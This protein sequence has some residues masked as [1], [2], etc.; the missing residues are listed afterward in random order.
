MIVFAPSLCG[1]RSSSIPVSSATQARI[2]ISPIASMP[3]CGAS[4]LCW[5]APHDVQG[6]RKLHEQINQAIEVDDRRLLILSEAS[7]ASPWVEH[8]I[9]RARRKEVQEKRQV[10]FPIR[11]ASYGTLHD[12]ECFDADTGKDLATEIR[13]YYIRT[14]QR[15]RATRRA[16][17][18]SLIDY[19]MI[20]RQC[21]AR[22]QRGLITSSD[23]NPYLCTFGLRH[24]QAKV[25]TESLKRPPG[26]N[27]RCFR[28]VSRPSNAQNGPVIEPESQGW[29]GPRLRQLS[30]VRL[31]VAH[32]G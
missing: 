29:G 17:V 1:R 21:R 15:G 16:T 4:R 6:G 10:L 32:S 20:S 25:E 18:G 19:S 24:N 27:R 12:W 26:L 30:V 9:R 28:W 13:E 3:I 14:S 23:K 31:V 5:F 8:E 7:I 2:R 22:R 11:L